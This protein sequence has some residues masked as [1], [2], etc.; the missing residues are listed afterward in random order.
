[1]HEVFKKLLL[2]LLLAIPGFFAAAQEDSTSRLKLSKKALR[3]QSITSVGVLAGQSGRDL[4]LQ[5]VAGVQHKT[6]FAGIGTGLDYY[7]LRGVPLFADVRK[8]FQYAM[9]LFLYGDVGVQLPWMKGPRSDGWYETVY[10][11]GLYYDVGAGCRFKIGIRRYL[12]L[13]AGYSGKTMQETTKSTF[14]P[15]PPASTTTTKTFYNL[16][17]I[18]I[19]AGFQF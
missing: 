6:W 14:V 10:K 2:A 15:E 9:P 1:M 16:R 17:R 3:F 12:L 5:T 11:T 19:K 8:H 13:S 7:Y 4:Q 18:S